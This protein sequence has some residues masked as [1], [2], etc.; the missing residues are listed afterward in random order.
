MI[1]FKRN[2]QIK[3][4]KY[5]IEINDLERK[6]ESLEAPEIRLEKAKKTLKKLLDFDY[7]GVNEQV[8]EE[9]VERII[10]H[11]DYFEWKLNFMKDS[12]KLQ[13]IGKNKADS[14]VADYEKD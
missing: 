3:I 7:N 10:V 2:Y 1:D 9:T 5:K 11:K 13:I 4:E 8:I 6:L 12:I 14:Y